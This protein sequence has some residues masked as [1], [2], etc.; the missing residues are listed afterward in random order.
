M[1]CRKVEIN[2]IL[3]YWIIET[4][5][6]C[7]PCTGREPA[8]LVLYQWHNSCSFVIF[9]RLRH[10]TFY[11]QVILHTPVYRTTQ[12]STILTFRLYSWYFILDLKQLENSNGLKQ[13]L[14]PPISYVDQFNPTAKRLLQRVTGKQS[15]QSRSH[16]LLKLTCTQYPAIHT[17]YTLSNCTISNKK[18]FNR[19][20]DFLVIN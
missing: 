11:L 12:Y 6:I 14:L 15:D 16:S 17:N 3:L 8:L 4:P 20:S 7:P 18:D 13:F 19:S 10:I 9:P 1:T 5:L 2:L